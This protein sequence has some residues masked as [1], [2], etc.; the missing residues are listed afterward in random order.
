MAVCYSL[1]GRSESTVRHPVEARR[2][3]Y[4]AFYVLQPIL[5]GFEGD[6]V[7]SKRVDSAAASTDAERI[8]DCSAANMPVRT[9]QTAVPAAAD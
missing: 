9:T 5:A 3:G 2:L 6:A 4:W 8:L 1:L 7:E